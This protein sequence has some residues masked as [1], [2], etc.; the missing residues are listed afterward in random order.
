MVVSVPN[1]DGHAE[2]CCATVDEQFAAIFTSIN[3]QCVK[4]KGSVR[5]QLFFVLR[6]TLS[7]AWR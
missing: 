1:C 7:H 4:A 6:R 3:S 5:I 2:A